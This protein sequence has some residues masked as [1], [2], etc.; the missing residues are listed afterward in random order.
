MYCA[1]C[2]TVLPENAKF[3][4]R[5]GKKQRNW[6]VDIG[7]DLPPLERLICS[8]KTGDLSAINELI[9]RS[10]S[11]VYYNC[12]KLLGDKTLAQEVTQDVFITVFQKLVTLEQ[13]KA[14]IVWVQKIALQ[15]CKERLYSF[16]S[17]VMEDATHP[18]TTEVFPG[19]PE[20]VVPD[21]KYDTMETRIQIV[22]L[23]DRLPAPQRICT[24]MFSYDD[25]TVQEIA[26]LLEIS[27]N[28]VKTRLQCAREE[29]WTGINN[30]VRDGVLDGSAS[31]LLPCLR[32]YLCEDAEATSPDEGPSQ[33]MN[34][35]VSQADY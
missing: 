32:Y 7:R 33:L 20:T 27:E 5:C 29:L 23:V 25:M 28:T 11:M 34:K 31:E 8:A 24:I 9:R 18:T 12:L 26:G 15:K 21:K 10:Q 14:Y 17:V 22:K 4:L 16:S 30:L 1:K 13:P 3:C 6:P 19:R 2:G 35:I